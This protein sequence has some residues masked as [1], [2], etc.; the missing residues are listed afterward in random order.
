MYLIRVGRSKIPKKTSDVICQRMLPNCKYK[1]QL[2][3]LMWSF[4]KRHIT[5]WRMVFL[6]SPFLWPTIRLEIPFRKIYLRKVW[7][8]VFLSAWPFIRLSH[9]ELTSLD[10]IFFLYFVKYMSSKQTSGKYVTGWRYI[11]YNAWAKK[12]PGIFF[13]RIVI[14]NFV[15]AFTLASEITFHRFRTFFLNL[16]AS[17]IIWGSQ[18]LKLQ[19]KKKFDER[20]E[21]F[22]QNRY[23]LWY[24]EK[25]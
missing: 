13:I 23:Y 15:L 18:H 1:F 14:E 9:L 6:V 8:E 3:S 24:V 2:W 20:L 17:K 22:I 19:R 12:I 7:L 11:V 5:W 10:T 16:K 21:T 4:F 25:K